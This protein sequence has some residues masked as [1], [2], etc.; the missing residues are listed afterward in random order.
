MA[1]FR[2]FASLSLTECKEA[3]IADI[4]CTALEHFKG[5]GQCQLQNYLVEESAGMV[6]F[7]LSFISAL[8]LGG[9]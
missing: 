3:C 1:S 5:S 2:F 4:S 9:L 6:S 7:S 8:T